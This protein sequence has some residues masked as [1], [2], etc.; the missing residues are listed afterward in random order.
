[1]RFARRVI[2]P[3]VALFLCMKH[4]TTLLGNESEKLMPPQA[5]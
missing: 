3:G 5:A 1:M 2:P 4:S